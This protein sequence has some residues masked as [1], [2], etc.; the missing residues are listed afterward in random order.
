M[1]SPNESNRS[2]PRRQLRK[3]W[4][5]PKIY[6]FGSLP[7]RQLRKFETPKTKPRQGSLPRRQ[8]RKDEVLV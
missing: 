3:Y 7:R 4:R 8:L 2:L 6:Q 5:T 1:Q